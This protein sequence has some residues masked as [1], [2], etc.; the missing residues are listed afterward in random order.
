LESDEHA[1]CPHFNKKTP[2]KR[3]RLGLHGPSTRYQT[4][5]PWLQLDIQIIKFPL[6]KKE[7]LR[8]PQRAR[9]L[10]FEFQSKL[11][12]GCLSI[13]T[14]G[15]KHDNP[16]SVGSAFIIPELGVNQSWSLPSYSTVFH[17]ELWALRKSID[18][19]FTLDRNDVIIFSDSLS[20]LQVGL[21][22]TNCEY[23][24]LY[25]NEYQKLLLSFEYKFK[26]KNLYSNELN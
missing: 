26:N 8:N 6:S 19:I 25:S 16:N 17:A 5:S 15:S 20:S 22:F 13:Y 4:T 11:P 7:S 9:Q 1:C 12:L 23:N 18:F 10:F 21:A 3:R 14:D 24:F 2:R